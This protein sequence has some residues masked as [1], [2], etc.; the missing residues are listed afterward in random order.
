MHAPQLESRE[1]L[2]AQV[3]NILGAVA[4]REPLVVDGRAGWRVVRIL[5]A[6]Q[7]SIRSGGIP[8]ALDSAVVGTGRGG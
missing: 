4:G 2:A 1:A 3:E 5:E 8:V 7:K 6:A